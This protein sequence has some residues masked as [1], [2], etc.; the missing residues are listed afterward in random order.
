[1]DL[2]LIRAIIEQAIQDKNNS[3]TTQE[4]MAFAELEAS[5][6]QLLVKAKN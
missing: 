5:A 6:K 3:R 4:H 2:D 1:M